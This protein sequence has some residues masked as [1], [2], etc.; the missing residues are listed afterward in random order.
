MTDYERDPAPAAPPVRETERTTI[1]HDGGNRGG[2]SGVAITLLVIIALLAILF[3][4][5]QGN[6]NHAAREAGVNAPNVKAPDINVKVPD[7]KV[8]VPKIDVKTEDS[9]VGNKSAD[10]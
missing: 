9:S 8:T 10:R 6:F 5:F 3:F 1:I 4:L 7:V 2:G